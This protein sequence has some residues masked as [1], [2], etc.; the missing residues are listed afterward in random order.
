MPELKQ[1]LKIHKQK[2]INLP[3]KWINALRPIGVICF[4]LI[5]RMTRKTKFTSRSFCCP[6]YKFF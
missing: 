6:N 2:L 5:L 3:K 1:N 4:C